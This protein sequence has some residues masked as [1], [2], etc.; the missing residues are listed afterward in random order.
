MFMFEL[1]AYATIGIVAGFLGGLFGIGGGLITV[2]FLTLMFHLLSFPNERIMHMAI[3]TSLAAMVFTSASSAWAH[4]LKKGIR[5]E[6]FWI[7]LPGVVIGSFLGA[8]LDLYLSGKGL[9]IFFATCEILTGIYFLLSFNQTESTVTIEFAYLILIAFLGVLIGGISTMLG[10]GGGLISVPILT[11]FGLSLKQSI[12]TSAALGF[13]IAIIG[14]FSFWYAGLSQS[15]LSHQ[16]V[17]YLYIPAFILIGLFSS[18]AA[19]YGA[20]ATY[21]LPTH[22]LRQAFGILLILIGL[23]M[24]FQ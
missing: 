7:L 17:S 21:L 8:I 3:G 22:H 14:A 18:I 20:K 23:S 10:I 6:L 16:Q 19:P 4:Y 15:N 5:W 24:Y 2:P 12:S 13:I 11:F 9:A 1:L